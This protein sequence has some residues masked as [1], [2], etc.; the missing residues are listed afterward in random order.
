MN[1]GGLL[2]IRVGRGTAG[3]YQVELR[4]DDLVRDCLARHIPFAHRDLSEAL[5]DGPIVVAGGLF[6]AADVQRRLADHVQRGGQLQILGEL[7]EF[8]EHFEPCRILADGVGGVAGELPEPGRNDD[9]LEFRLIGKDGRD[10]FVFLFSRTD[11][12][13]AVPTRVGASRLTVDLAPRGCAAVRVL[14]GRL[15]ACYVKGL[16]EHTGQGMPVGVLLGPDHLKSSDACDLSAIR[17]GNGFDIKTQGA[18]T[19]KV[20][21]SG[22]GIPQIDSGQAVRPFIEGSSLFSSV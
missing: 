12:V 5:P 20:T 4:F 2:E 18:A 3:N 17:R 10:V 11:E 9:H 6:M 22:G 19:L 8:D 13:R 7:P 15:T 1:S 14:D 16:Q 21:N